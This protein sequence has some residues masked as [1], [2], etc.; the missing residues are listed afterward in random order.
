MCEP[1][2]DRGA[3]IGLLDDL[4]RRAAARGAR[5]DL[6]LVGGG[7]MVLVYNA[8]RTTKDIEGIFEPKML[9]YE[10]AADIAKERGLPPDWLNDA[11][12]VFPFPLGQEDAAAKTFYE[13]AGLAVRVAS[14]RYLFLM[15]AWSGREAD[16]DDLRVLWPLCHYANADECL[17]EIEA[18]YPS[19]TLR[20][21]TRYIVE[22]IAQADEKGE[23]A[24]RD[25]A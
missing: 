5:V 17:D 2:L 15:K 22:A 14:P 3:I 13:G 7:A 6:F 10:L 12:K 8:T 9:A 19:A 18:A 20:P 4:S 16:E 21:R 24:D 25:G 11:V 23:L 1:T